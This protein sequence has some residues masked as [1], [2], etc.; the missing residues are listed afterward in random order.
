MSNCNTF[1]FEARGLDSISE[2][3]KSYTVLSKARHPL[4]VFFERSVLPGR[5]D[6]KMG[7]AHSL[8]ALSVRV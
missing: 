2:A 3:V 5:N 4:D 1:A 8:H 7:P 6:A